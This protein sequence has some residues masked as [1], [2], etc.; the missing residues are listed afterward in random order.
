[1]AAQN[2]LVGSSGFAAI[3]LVQ[4]VPAPDVSGTGEIIKIIVQLIIG[5]A[6]LVVLF[7]KKTN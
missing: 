1:M 6:T 7:R 4:M 2:L 3:E 5:L